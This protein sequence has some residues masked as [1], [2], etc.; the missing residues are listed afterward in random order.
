M[1][2]A[3]S[4]V[5]IRRRG[6][7]RTAASVVG[8]ALV[9]AACSTGQ[10]NA[11]PGTTTSAD[12]S[13]TTTAAAGENPAAVS[14]RV[15]FLDQQ[16]A[17]VGTEPL[18]RPV[19]RKVHP[20]GVAAAALD[21]LF[22]GPTAQERAD[23]LRLI[24]SGATGYRGLRIAEGVAHVTLVGGCSSGGSTMTIAGELMPTL[25]QFATVQHVKIYAPDGSTEEPT[26]TGDSIPFCLEP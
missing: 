2:L 8:A 16:H 4:L 11:G 7:L 12:A 14:A 24:T 19:E 18:F 5:A 20:P 9:L 21:S 15:W 13:T 6:G 23:G 10:P 22:A 25:K 3:V 17:A 1:G 26:G